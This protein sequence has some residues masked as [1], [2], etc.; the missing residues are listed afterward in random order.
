MRASSHIQ[1]KERKQLTL[2][3]FKGVDFSSSPLRVHSN[4]ASNMQNFI[5][6]YGV[7]RKRNGW[8]ELFRIE[9][10]NGN[11]Q[12]INGIFQFIKGNRKDLLVHAGKQRKQMRRRTILRLTETLTPTNKTRRMKTKRSSP[13]LRN[14]VE[15][16]SLNLRRRK[17]LLNL[18]NKTPKMLAVGVRQNA[19]KN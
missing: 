14:K 8:N 13:I 16:K 15:S 18:V 6:E 17:S 5:N 10:E 12:P 7:N 9:D 2:E 1:L 4:R 3:N 19:S 11:A